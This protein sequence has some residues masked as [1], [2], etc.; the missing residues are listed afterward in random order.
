MDIDW[1][2]MCESCLRIMDD[3][4]RER[5]EKEKRKSAEIARYV[6]EEFGISVDK[7]KMKKILDTL[8]E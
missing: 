4:R 3:N 6:L 8:K 7:E 1:S 2:N 5:L